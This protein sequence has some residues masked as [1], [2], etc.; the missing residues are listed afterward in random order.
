[1]E[2][3]LLAGAKPEGKQNHFEANAVHMLKLYKNKILEM[4]KYKV[5][6]V[7]G[8]MEGPWQNGMYHF[9]S[10][11]KPEVL[12]RFFGHGITRGNEIDRVAALHSIINNSMIKGDA[13][14]L[15]NSGHVNAFIAPIMII[16]YVDQPLMSK[17]FYEANPQEIQRIPYIG[18]KANIGAIVLD[19]KYYPLINEFK[20]IA[21][22]YNFIK[23]E[24][25]PAYFQSQLPNERVV[26][27]PEE[28]KEKDERDFGKPEE[29]NSSEILLS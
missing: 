1:M 10:L 17:N 12:E 14:L 27:T 24:D 3:E 9:M 28:M 4:K 23:S 29:R 15:A 25:L 11:I 21:P 13:G 2:N 16:S 18:W 7:E 26:M 5:Y 8:G 6:D 19:V 20:K 22:K